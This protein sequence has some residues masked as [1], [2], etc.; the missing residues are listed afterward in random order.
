[1]DTGVTVQTEKCDLTKRADLHLSSIS[2]LHVCL[3]I[4]RFLFKRE[5]HFTIRAITIEPGAFKASTPS[6]PI[7][8]KWLQNIFQLHKQIFLNNHE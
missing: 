8:R 7:V 5:N 6:D 3:N 2:D 4:F 1:M